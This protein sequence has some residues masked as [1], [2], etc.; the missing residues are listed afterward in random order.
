MLHLLAEHVGAAFLAPSAPKGPVP[1]VECPC[2]ADAEERLVRIDR[3][4]AA[5]AGVP[6]VVLLVAGSES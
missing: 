5:D 6:V 3:N 1:T 2:A 4:D